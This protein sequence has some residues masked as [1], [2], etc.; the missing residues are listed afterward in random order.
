MKVKLL[1]KLRKKI[2]SNLLIRRNNSKI[3]INWVYL[4]VTFKG[5]LYKTEVRHGAYN[6]AVFNALL[7]EL[8]HIVLENYIKKF[9][10]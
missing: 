1:K 4:S 5:M 7:K 8:E 10:V 3:T 6:D 2:R 9:R